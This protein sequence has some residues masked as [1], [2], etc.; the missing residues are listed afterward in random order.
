MR[1]PVQIGERLSFPTASRQNWP[2]WNW[3]LCVANLL[4]L[5]I[6]SQLGSTPTTPTNALLIDGSC[7]GV[8]WQGF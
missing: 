8:R 6:N 1:S 7:H 3:N 4:I 2:N 5:Q